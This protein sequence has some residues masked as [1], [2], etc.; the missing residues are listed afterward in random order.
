[1]SRSPSENGNC[2][3]EQKHMLFGRQGR[4]PKTGG[5]KPVKDDPEEGHPVCTSEARA[6]KMGEAAVEVAWPRSLTGAR[7][8]S[9]PLTRQNAAAPS[10]I[11]I[12]PTGR[13]TRPYD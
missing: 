9:H 6:R 10:G 2:P 11:H 8:D 12:R 5:Q 7:G 13:R 3:V 1:M 4:R